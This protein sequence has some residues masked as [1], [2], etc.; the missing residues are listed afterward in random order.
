MR[1]RRRL[2]T[3]LAAGA[4]AAAAAV[5]A[6]AQPA[7]GYRAIDLGACPSGDDSIATDVN[8]AGQVVGWCYMGQSFVWQ[9][10]KMTTLAN[11]PGGSYSRAN[12]VNNWGDVVGEAANATGQT[13]AVLWRHGKAIDLGTLSGGTDSYA[14]GIN[15]RGEVVGYSTIA[16]G[17]T[18]AFVRRHGKMVDLGALPGQSYSTA[19]GVNDRGTVVGVSTH[20]SIYRTATV[21]KHG[22]AT[23]LGRPYGNAESAAVAVNDRGQVA[24]YSFGTAN[25]AFLYDRGRLVDVG[26]DVNA[27][28]GGGYTQPEAINNRG[29]VVGMTEPG[30]FLWDAG[31][32]TKLSGAGGEARGINDAGTVAGDVQVAVPGSPY[33]AIHA[34]LW[35]RWRAWAGETAAPSPKLFGNYWQ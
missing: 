13:H 9:H 32:V 31:K 12:A 3:V 35:V 23:D 27:E 34:T 22:R 7:R 15:S 20:D 33:P 4:L 16:D 14:T 28:L 29:Q 5:P 21:W 6:T 19:A 1:Q 26:A 25:H 8:N 11:P 30:A 17:N 18:H 10:G 24:A 2:A